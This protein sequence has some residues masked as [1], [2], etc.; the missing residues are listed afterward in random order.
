MQIFSKQT[1]LRFLQAK[2]FY[3]A[4]KNNVMETL[5]EEVTS[6]FTRAKVSYDSRDNQWILE[7]EYCYEDKIKKSKVIL[8]EGFQYDLATIPR[9]FWTIV[10]PH[11]LSPEAT[12]IHDYLYISRG[13]QKKCFHHKEILGCIETKNIR[14]SRKEADDLFLRMMQE[15]G[16]IWWRRLLGY[17]GVRFFG[18]FYWKPNEE[19]VDD[20]IINLSRQGKHK[21][22]GIR[23]I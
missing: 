8:Y 12:L 16:V 9:Y 17:A 6:K 22:A 23:L 10:G 19:I 11:E 2:E 4:C 20:C 7:K 18:S 13:G 1:I 21:Q 3:N 15:A 5:N 14:Y